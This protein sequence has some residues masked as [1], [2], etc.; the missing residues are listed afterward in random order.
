M[1]TEDQLRQLRPGDLVKYHGVQWRVRDYSTYRDPYGYE[2]EEWLLKS[3]LSKEYYLLREVDPEETDDRVTW[4]IAE[5]L[6]NPTIYEPGSSRDLLVSL[7]QDM[8]S[9]KDPYPRL[10]TLNRVYSF[11]SKTEGTYEGDD[12][13]ERRITWDYWDAAELWNLALEA[14]GNSK[15]AVYSTRKAHPS[16]FSNIQALSQNESYRY[17]QNKAGFQ[18]SGNPKDYVMGIY[19]PMTQQFVV[20]LLLLVIGFMFM[21]S[22]I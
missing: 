20:A 15:L 21:M 19:M 14:W 18:R 6:R 2:T 5:D 4:Y 13:N 12:G 22:G 11:D 9:G 3:P 10:Q 16:D 17:A 1:A 7:A 8:R